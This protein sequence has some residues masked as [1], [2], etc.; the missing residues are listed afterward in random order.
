MS[1]ARESRRVAPSKSR[2]LLGGALVIAAAALWGTLGIFAR[3]LGE[4]GLA[5]LELAS[6]RAASTVVGL[7]LW[8]LRRPAR[9]RIQGRDIPFFLAYGLVGIALFHF[10]YLAAVERTTIAI[11]VALLYTAPGI[12]VIGSRLWF[13]EAIDRNRLVSLALVLAGAFLVTG[14]LR[15]LASREVTITG[16]ALA[17]GL[18]AGATYGGYTLFGKAALRRYDTDQTVFFSFLFGALAL[19]LAAPPWRPFLEHP[20][21]LV[22]LLLLGLA[23]TLV[24]YLLYITALRHVPP[25]TASMLASIEPVVATLL[26]FFWLGEPLGVDQVLGIALIVAAALVLAARADSDSVTAGIDA[27]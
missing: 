24:P 2:V 4:T 25:S 9:F 11:A 12:V 27:A 13:G 26:G 6:V 23:A 19:G 3:V 18:A 22:P 1:E 17:F 7:S 15:L 8:F 20:D 21:A 5:P 16:A 14:A 10:T